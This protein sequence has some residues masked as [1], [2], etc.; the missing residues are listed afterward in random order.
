MINLQNKRAEISFF[1][2]RNDTID[3]EKPYFECIE[4]LTKLI[5]GRL[6]YGQLIFEPGCGSA[7]FGL[8][9]TSRGFSVV[10]CD[11]SPNL[12]K[13]VTKKINI[14]FSSYYPILCDVEHAPFRLS[15]FDYCFS[16]FILHHFKSL[17]S[18]LYEIAKILKIRGELWVAEPNGSNPVA[19]IKNNIARHIMPQET[20]LEYGWS[21][22]NEKVHSI[23]TYFTSLSM[24]GYTK[25]RYNT[26]YF[27][28]HNFFNLF[29]LICRKF[30]PSF[31]GGT[32][33]L[34][35]CQKI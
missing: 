20:L 11:L 25:I 32:D 30:L 35:K 29:Y 21:T 1:N 8:E 17:N 6:G 26:I 34:L 5:R 15:V 31:L 19:A 4:I 23:K 3:F 18:V 14:R 24:T 13:K 10:G 7:V 27:P 16:G 33:V 2:E 28:S 9:L 22:P 12:L